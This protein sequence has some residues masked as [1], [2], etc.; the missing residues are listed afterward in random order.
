[1]KAD[2]GI[3]HW[4][5]RADGSVYYDLPFADIAYFKRFTLDAVAGIDFEYKVQKG[6]IG[7]FELA[8]WVHWVVGLRGDWSAT[9]V[10][11]KDKEINNYPMY[12][13]VLGFDGERTNSRNVTLGLIIGATYH[14]HVA[15]YAKTRF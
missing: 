13:R 9:T 15:D 12:G 8:R 1:M 3:V 2:G 4:E 5:R 11:H 7:K 14:F 10:E 6:R